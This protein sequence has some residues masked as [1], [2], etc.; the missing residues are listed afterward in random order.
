MRSRLWPQPRSRVR[1]I[2]ELVP[3]PGLRRHSHGCGIV[4]IACVNCMFVQAGYPRNPWWLL[5]QTAMNDLWRTFGTGARAASMS[6]P[7]SARYGPSQL[8][9][10]FVTP[11]L[12]TSTYWTHSR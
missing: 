6:H 1:R 7:L 10:N 4:H 12:V 9:F 3:V 2:P 11:A 5:S 8:L